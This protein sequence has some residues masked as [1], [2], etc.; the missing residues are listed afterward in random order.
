MP[1]VCKL[2]FA[3][4]AHINGIRFFLLQMMAVIEE[5]EITCAKF[6]LEKSFSN[7]L[8]LTVRLCE[9]NNDNPKAATTSNHETKGNC[10]CERYSY[11]PICPLHI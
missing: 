8:T 11:E 5:M 1:P 2:S 9:S 6:E 4:L 10:H 7:H 3:V